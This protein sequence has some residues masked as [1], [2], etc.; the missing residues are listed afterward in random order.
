[1]T[2]TP[3][4]RSSRMPDWAVGA[5]ESL[6]WWGICLGVWLVTLSAVSSQEWLV[7]VLA[8]VPCGVLATVGRRAAADGWSFRPA[9]FS[10]ALTLP[11]S[12]AA[13]TAA[14]LAGALPGRRRSGRFR[15]VEISDA[16]GESR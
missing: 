15:R 9:W 11:V 3:R 7:S 2:V 1:M 8:S 13:D 14:V 16:T 12:I 4:R 10:S 6:V 5:V